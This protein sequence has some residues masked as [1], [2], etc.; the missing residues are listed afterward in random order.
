MGRKVIRQHPRSDPKAYIGK[1]RDRANSWKPSRNPLLEQMRPM[2]PA[3]CVKGS[4]RV[5]REATFDPLRGVFVVLA[6]PGDPE[7]SPRER[8]R[9]LG[10]VD[11]SRDPGQLKAV[12]AE[13]KA[14]HPPKLPAIHKRRPPAGTHMGNDLGTI[15]QMAELTVSD[16][17]ALWSNYQKAMEKSIR[18]NGDLEGLTWRHRATHEPAPP[19]HHRS[20]NKSTACAPPPFGTFGP[21]NPPPIQPFRGGRRPCKAFTADQGERLLTWKEMQGDRCDPPPP[22]KLP[23]SYEADDGHMDTMMNDELSFQLKAPVQKQRRHIPGHVGEI[24]DTICPT[25]DSERRKLNALKMH[26]FT[27]TKKPSP[28]PP[29]TIGATR[30]RRPTGSF[31]D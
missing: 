9:G 5:A 29:V 13:G 20:R 10:A 2:P 4:C 30:Y 11:P 23:P 16:N 22:R 28:P 21:E 24:C 6:R 14:R 19:L 7:P 3:T 15:M 27:V 31:R 17:A 12:L 1:K 25:G 8:R 18:R 26:E